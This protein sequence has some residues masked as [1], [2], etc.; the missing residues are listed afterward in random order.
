MAALERIKL[1]SYEY[2]GYNRVESNMA[3]MRSNGT[4]AAFGCSCASI[5]FQ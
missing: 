1:T 2:G 5:L 4:G 3:L